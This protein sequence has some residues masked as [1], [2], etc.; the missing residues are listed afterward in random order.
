MFGPAATISVVITAVLLALWSTR[1]DLA[2]FY[3][4]VTER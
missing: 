4:L 2:D 1:V 3:F